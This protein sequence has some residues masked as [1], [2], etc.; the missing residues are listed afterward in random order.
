MPLVV[1]YGTRGTF[2]TLV[3]VSSDEEY[4]FASLLIQPQNIPAIPELMF[5]C[6]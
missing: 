5:L 1:G 6:Y 4:W 2:E 3:L